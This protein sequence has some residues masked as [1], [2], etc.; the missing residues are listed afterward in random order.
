MMIRSI[1]EWKAKKA[2]IDDPPGEKEERTR[3][4][5]L[6]SLLCLEKSYII[7]FLY[8]F[9]EIEIFV[10]SFAMIRDRSLRLLLCYAYILI[11]V[12]RMSNACLILIDIPRMLDIGNDTIHELFDN[13]S[14]AMEEQRVATLWKVA[15]GS[16]SVPHHHGRLV[17]NGNISQRKGRV[18]CGMQR[19]ERDKHLSDLIMTL[20][21]F[22]NS[23]RHRN[24]D[25][26]YT[27]SFHNRIE[28]S[29]SKVFQKVTTDCVCQKG[30]VAFNGAVG[31]GTSILEFNG[32]ESE[33]FGMKKRSVVDGASMEPNGRFMIFRLISPRFFRYWSVF[34]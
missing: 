8:R 27:I 30:I 20:V 17:V 23:V 22:A 33:V 3:A 6:D 15:G 18:D 5:N 32:N 11:D 21:G 4:N 19:K 10:F 12:C 13:L 2:M 26:L 34:R 28:I 14:V 9:N 24:D 31:F 25:G 29:M 1:E 7:Y 16:G